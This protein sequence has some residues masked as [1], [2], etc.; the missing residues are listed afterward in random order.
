[1]YTCLRMHTREYIQLKIIKINSYKV[2]HSEYP[3]FKAR[4]VGKECFIFVYLYSQNLL[5]LKYHKHYY[6][7]RNYQERGV[8]STHMKQ[9]SNTY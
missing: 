1:M 5:K 2:L 7:E 6:I 9:V 3:Q 8:R 4:S